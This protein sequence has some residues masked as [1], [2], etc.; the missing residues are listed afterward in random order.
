[1]ELR[2]NVTDT[3]L[4]F[5][6]GGMRASYTSAV[7]VALLEAG[8]HL[9]FVA[10]ISAGSSNT[11]NYLARD[12]WRARHSFVDFAADPKFG[13]WKTFLRGDGLF[14]A[15]YIYEETGL[16]DQALP[17]PWETFL[18]NPATLRLGAFDAESG[19]AIWWGR[20]DIQEPPDLMVRVRASSTM[21]VLMPP[22][23]LNGRTYVDGALGPDGG[24]PLSAA[25][26]A[27]HERF[28]A[29]L[30]R[31]RGYVKAPERFPRFYLRYFRKHPAIAEALL[32]RWQRYN[33]TRERLFELER[34][35]RAYLFVPETMPVSNGEKDVVKL[36]AAHEAGLAQARRELPAIREFLGLPAV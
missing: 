30:T 25:I 8:I 11:A 24:I 33:A 6:G 21:P 15:K 16:P 19:Q 2:S 7:A 31:E 29:V 22:V 3:A 1:M 26:D 28:L 32:T 13:N 9:D 35:G 34:E 23:R 5:E 17:Y 12:P 36:A 4:L 20:E 18:A 10:G 27:G 14:N